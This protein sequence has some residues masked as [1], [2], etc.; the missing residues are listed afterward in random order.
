[1]G[2]DAEYQRANEQPMAK[3]VQHGP[4]G[5]KNGREVNSAKNEER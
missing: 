2:A 3:L 4:K 5:K 1:M